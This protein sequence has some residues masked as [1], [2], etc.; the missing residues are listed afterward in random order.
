MAHIHR[1]N[2]GRSAARR[3][4]AFTLI[5]LLV[6]IGIIAVLLSILIP[7]VSSVRTTGYVSRTDARILA[8][9]A[10]IENYQQ[11]FGAY[12]GPLADNQLQPA[13][14]PLPGASGTATTTENLTLGLLGGLKINPANGA[15]SYD[16]TVVGKGPIS[17][18]PLKPKQYAGFIDP[19]TA[20][21]EV[22][23]DPARPTAWL[24]WKGR[25]ELASA[26]TAY[27]DTEIPEFLDAFPDA[28]PIIYV[29]AQVGANGVIPGVPGTRT[30]PTWFPAQLAP[31][32]FPPTS[33]G[34]G[35]TFT[36]AQNPDYQHIGYY[37]ALPVD[38]NKIKIANA[39]LQPRQKDGFLLLAA[40][41]NRKFLD[42]DDR[43][44]GGSK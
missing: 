39:I 17:L 31:Y 29:R 16:P 23:K 26:A 3:P 9:T 38:Q 1:P 35:P 19:S 42:A 12:P 33:M 14:A 41:A 10:A 21:L 27:N 25:P 5:E 4:R 8:L 36:P 22:Q 30:T 20:G 11:V 6:V 7:V 28:L 24:P 13:N 18:N 32:N 44:N 40:G 34:P 15:L 2:L 37:F 43:S